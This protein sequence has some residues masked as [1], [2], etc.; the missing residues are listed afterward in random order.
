MSLNELSK[1]E[2]VDRLTNSARLLDFWGSAIRGDW[3]TIDG[4]S[5]K[6]QL[7]HISRYMR[8]EGVAPRIQDV[9]ICILNEHDDE[10]YPHWAGSGLFSFNQHNCYDEN[11]GEVQL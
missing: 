9:G 1:E 11:Y 6:Y 3:S 4:R 2:L 7:G 5:S 10:P 8:G